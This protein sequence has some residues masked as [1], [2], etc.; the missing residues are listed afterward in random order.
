MDQENAFLHTDGLDWAGEQLAEAGHQ[1]SLVAHLTRKVHETLIRYAE[2][3]PEEAAAAMPVLAQLI[4]GRMLGEEFW[5]EEKR[6]ARTY[7]W[8]PIPPN[9]LHPGDVVRV[10]LDAYTGE[11]AQHNGKRGRVAA[12]RGGVIV[13][14]DDESGSGTRMG[15]RHPSEKLERRIPFRTA[16]QVPARPTTRRTTK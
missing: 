12:L 4:Q 6:F 5:T 8:I 13:S 15:V 9:S 3:S 11:M 7:T 1:H 16:K 10:K 2:A 14:Y